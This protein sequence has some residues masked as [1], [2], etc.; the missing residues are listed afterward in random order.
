MTKE[1]IDKMQQSLAKA[2]KVTRKEDDRYKRKYIQNQIYADLYLN[3]LFAV[4]ETYDFNLGVFKMELVDKDIVSIFNP[5][6]ISASVFMYEG[7][8]VI[9]LN[10]QSD[11]G[12]RV[13]EPEFKLGEP[14]DLDVVNDILRENGVSLVEKHIIEEGRGL[15]EDILTFDA[16]PIV[17]TRK[18]FLEMEKEKG[19]QK[20]KK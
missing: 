2:V 17:E 16:T 14:F 11:D 12:K 20:I 6:D 9:H 13:G 7:T 8:G 5:R 1:F 18:R 3:L 10:Y 4:I 19:K 15:E